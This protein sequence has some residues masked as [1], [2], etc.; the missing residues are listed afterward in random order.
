[1][2][3]IITIANQ[4]GGVGKTTT[5]V[6][7]ASCLAVAE[8]RSLLVDIDPQA[9]AGSGVG[10]KLEEGQN[11]VY[12]VLIKK[13]KLEKI[14][15]PTTIKGLDL[16][17]SSKELIGAEAELLSALYREFRLKNALAELKDRYDFIIIDCPPS[18]GMLTINALTA[19]DS[20]IIPLQCEY[21]ALEGISQLAYTIKCIKRDLNPILQIEGVVLTMYDQRTNI[22]QQVA[23]EAQE[24]FKEKVFSTIIPRNVSLSEAPSFGMPIII[25]EIRSAGAQA[26]LKLAK[27]V[28]D[29][30]QKGL[31]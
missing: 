23:K 27:E 12:Q 11:T 19:A 8:K 22:S 9:N 28:I 6:N 30:D 3:K 13:E 7:L 24:F 10:Y 16:V 4:K 21:Y 15:W 17:P 31:R 26:Y 2:G 14:I 18:L 5:A 25:Y 29:H 20:V 1:M